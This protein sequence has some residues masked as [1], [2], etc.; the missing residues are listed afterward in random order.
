MPNKVGRKKNFINSYNIVN[1][2]VVGLLAYKLFILYI[3][4]IFAEIDYFSI[5]WLYKTSLDL[6]QIIYVFLLVLQN[7]FGLFSFSC[8]SFFR[9]LVVFQVSNKRCTR[10]RVS[11]SL[12]LVGNRSPVN[13]AFDILNVANLLKISS[14]LERME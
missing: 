2:E 13:L 3:F 10:T 9:C 6:L 14:F 1:R 5:D 4:Y 12:S 8:Y 11:S 7:L